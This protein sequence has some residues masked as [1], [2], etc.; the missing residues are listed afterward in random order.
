MLRILK[1]RMLLFVQ[2]QTLDKERP[3][4]VYWLAGPVAAGTDTAGYHSIAPVRH[5]MRSV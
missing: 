1:T 3:W 4:L 5:P 2:G